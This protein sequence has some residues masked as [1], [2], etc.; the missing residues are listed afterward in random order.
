[1][2]IT[3]TLNDGLMREYSIVITADEIETDR[4]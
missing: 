2:N 3:E 4:S 1:M